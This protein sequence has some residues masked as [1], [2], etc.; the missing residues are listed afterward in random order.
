[1]A[2]PTFFIIGAPKAGTTSLNFYL[3]QHPE[4]QM[5]E[6]KEPAFFAPPLGLAT[7]RLGIS[8]VDMI[9]SLDRYEQ[10]F[11]PT[12]Q[13][14][15]EG[16]TN[17]AEYPFR[18]RVPER[19]KERVPKAKFV[20][21]VRD[22]VDRTVSHY[23]HLVASAGERRPLAEILGGLPDPRAPCICASLYA[24]QLELYLHHFP[25]Q[26]I[27]VIDQAE[28]RAD[29][30]STL[31]KIFMFLSVDDTFDSP[32]FDEELLKGSEHRAYPPRFARFVSHTLRPYTRS[33]PLSPDT[34]RLLR[35]SLERTLLPP[36]QTSKLSDEL[37]SRLQ[38]FYAGEVE[39]LRA[40][41]G[42]TFPTWSI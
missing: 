10:L 1:M 29:R 23:D 33:L 18:Q 30:R 32:R 12:V 2:L 21:M 35:L 13:V 6:V 16:S 11:D 36:L 41:T 31:R 26:R 20:Y 3:E 40:L 39:R 28:L 34:R 22:P 25:Q 37:R 5:S 17:Y 8:R 4:I 19:I 24:M 27:L 42:E 7:S 9:S 38:E 14:R 15:G